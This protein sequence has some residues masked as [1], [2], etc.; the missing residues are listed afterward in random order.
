MDNEK[1]TEIIKKIINY[2][3]SENNRINDLIVKKENRS[4]SLG[5]TP[6][7]KYSIRKNSELIEMLN[8]Y[9]DGC[10]I[11]DRTNNSVIN[12]CLIYKKKVV[13]F[14]IIKFQSVIF[15]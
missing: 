7:L 12:D 10:Q 6:S 5:N 4:F 9:L 8:S 1:R 14:T 15:V 3:K 13:L 11:I 2:F